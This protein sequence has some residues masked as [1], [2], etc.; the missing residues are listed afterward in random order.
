[1]RFKWLIGSVGLLAASPAA[2]QLTS[3]TIANETGKAIQTVMAA[4][5]VIYRPDGGGQRRV[6]VPAGGT[7]T[8]R[9]DREGGPCEGDLIL[10]FD[11]LSEHVEQQ[12]YLCGPYLTITRDGGGIRV[13]TNLAPEG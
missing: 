5:H 6:G 4:G 7:V 2:A 13:T 3:F 8:M 11:D 12:V 1:M 10:T 9:F